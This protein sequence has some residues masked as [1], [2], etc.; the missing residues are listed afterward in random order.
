MSC[1]LKCPP[2]INFETPPA[3]AYNCTFEKGVFTPS[4]V[5]RCVYGEGVQVVQRSGFGSD[6]ADEGLLK[7]VNF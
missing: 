6:D 4:T 5:P 2:G 1:V 7:I 3:A